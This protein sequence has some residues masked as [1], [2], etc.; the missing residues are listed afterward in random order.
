MSKVSGSDSDVEKEHAI[1]DATGGS[2]TLVEKIGTFA[3]LRIRN[4]RFLLV[5]T[6]LSSAAQ[7]I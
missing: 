4:F 1:P 3:S 6:T 5:G 7:W 2:S